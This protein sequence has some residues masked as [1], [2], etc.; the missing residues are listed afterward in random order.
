MPS[1]HVQNIS[2]YLL[3]DTTLLC[4]VIKDTEM[5]NLAK[6]PPPPPTNTN[7]SNSNFKYPD[8]NKGQRKRIVSLRNWFN[9]IYLIY[10]LLHNYFLNLIHLNYVFEFRIF[11]EGKKYF[12]Y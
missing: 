4:Q 12:Q 7:T 5:L 6:T 1:F 8:N 3:E 10:L 11:W 2:P 9:S